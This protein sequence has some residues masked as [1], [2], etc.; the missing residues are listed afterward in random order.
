MKASDSEVKPHARDTQTVS[1][2]TGFQPESG[3]QKLQLLAIISHFSAKHLMEG[4]EEELMP[5]HLPKLP[6]NPRSHS[7]LIFKC[8]Q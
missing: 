6:L 4:K 3:L 8:K 7:E 5:L 2:Q 1:R